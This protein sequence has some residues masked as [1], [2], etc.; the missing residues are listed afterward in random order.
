M[1]SALVRLV[2]D[3]TMRRIQTVND[4]E[5]I[6][7]EPGDDARWS[8]GQLQS[9]LRI[10][11]QRYEKWIDRKV[12]SSQDRA[13]DGY[14]GGQEQ[15]WLL[16]LSILQISQ[17]KVDR[18]NPELSYQQIANYLLA[19][20][21]AKINRVP[22]KTVIKRPVSIFIKITSDYPVYTQLYKSR[23]RYIYYL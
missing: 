8:P 13:G 7:K 12:K 4:K 11:G 19:L 16:I 20:T 3:D 21:A 1:S 18:G 6:G 9:Q 14:D 5:R 2:N 22:C 15:L 23:L 17:R 10:I